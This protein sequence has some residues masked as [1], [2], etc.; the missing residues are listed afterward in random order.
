[1]NFCVVYNAAQH[2]NAVKQRYGELVW[3][4]P[5]T[6]PLND[7][8]SLGTRNGNPYLFTSYSDTSG[9]TIVDQVQR[10]FNGLVQ[11]TAEYQAHSGQ[12]KGDGVA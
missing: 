7:V 2:L 3:L 10:S 5:L 12:R 11:L 6:S 8:E 4:V 1:M 9:T